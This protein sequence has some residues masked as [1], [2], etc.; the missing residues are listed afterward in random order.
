MGFIFEVLDVNL[1][2]EVIVVIDEEAIVYGCR[3]VREE[4][5]LL[6]IF[7]GVV[8]VVV[9]KVVKRFVNKDKLIVMI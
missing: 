4:G 1:I 7:I 9:I 3:L 8:L 6:G 5:I 2:D